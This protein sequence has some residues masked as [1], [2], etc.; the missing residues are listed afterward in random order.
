MWQAN[1]Q[2]GKG[3][4]QETEHTNG[5]YDDGQHPGTSF[6][7]HAVKEPGTNLP[8]VRFDHAQGSDYALRMPDSVN[9]QKN[10]DDSA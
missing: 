4:C 6:A 1:A 9:K 8:G 7:Q 5:E 3:G 2:E 10:C